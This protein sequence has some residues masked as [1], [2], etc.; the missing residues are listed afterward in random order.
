MNRTYRFLATAAVALLFAVGCAQVRDITNALTNISRLQF[1]LANVSGFRL[2]GVDLSKV[3]EPSRLSIGDA[4]SLTNAF[5]RKSFPAEF[6]LNVDA[7]NPNTG[8]NG[9]R[10]TAMTLNDLDWR[11]L[12]DDKQTIN[13]GLAS[14]VSVPGTGQ[15]V[16]IPLRMGLDMYSFFADK[17]YDGI[18][19]LA[20]ALGGVNGS[21]AR[22]KLDAMPSVG[23]PFGAITYPGRIVIMDKSFTAS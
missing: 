22:V 15:S 12:I 19:S 23:T 7:K 20:L 21:A 16:T 3:S 18:L 11:L 4:L 5:A 9:T 10:Q 13:G 1:K 2:A 17:G 14:P 6:V 8:S